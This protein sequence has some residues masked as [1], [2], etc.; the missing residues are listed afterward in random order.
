MLNDYIKNILGGVVRHGL[1]LVAGLLAAYG[2]TADQQE[3]FVSS[4]TAVVVAIILFFISQ[5][6]SGAA[7]VKE[8]E[9]VDTALTLP[10]GTSKA[11][12]EDVIASK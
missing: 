6:W 4:T 2:V 5:F 1:T 11:K 3:S 9:K 7:K 10:A 12:L 8:V